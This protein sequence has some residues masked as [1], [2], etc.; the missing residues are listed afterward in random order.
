MVS[1]SSWASSERTGRPRRGRGIRSSRACP[2]RSAPAARRSCASAIETWPTLRPSGPTEKSCTCVS[3]TRAITSA[4]PVDRF[5]GL[6]DLGDR[7]VAGEH[8]VH[9]AGR[10]TTS[11]PM[12]ATNRH[13]RTCRIAAT[14]PARSP[15][16][17][18]TLMSRHRHSRRPR[19]VERQPS[20]AGRGDGA[21][22]RRPHR[23]PRA[24]RRCGPARRRSPRR[25]RAPSPRPRPAWRGRTRRRRRRRSAGPTRSRPAAGRRR[26]RSRPA[27]RR[28]GT[29]AGNPA[30]AQASRSSAARWR[31][32]AEQ[33]HVRR[34]GRAAPSAASPAAVASGLPASV[35]AWNTGPSGDSVSITSRRPPTAPIGRPP[36]MTLP[37]VVR[38][39]VTSYLAWA[40]PSSRRNPVIT[41]SNTS[42]A[43]TRS[44][45]AR[46]PSRNP[47]AGA[48]TPMLAATGST[49]TA[50][51]CVVELGHRRCTARRASRRPHR[52]ARR[53]CPAA[54]RRHT[55]AA[56]G[57]QR[58]GGAVEVAVE[59]SRCGRGR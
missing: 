44:H 27:C 26:R 54:E 56:G 4:L 50:A 6:H 35:P 12:A 34:R 36:P 32:R 42:S 11:A 15:S 40:P 55:A 49:I 43:P 24:R 48:T 53:R 7:V 46:S 38:S 25:R 10:S 14:L 2:G 47:A 22:R 39:G 31:A 59:R 28:P 23:S 33:L 21:A 8:E 51:T 3:S 58:V 19:R 37:N 29:A 41:S 20:D 5:D 1:P 16:R 9:D 45:S 17:I 13:E 52:P 30:A 18:G 57:E